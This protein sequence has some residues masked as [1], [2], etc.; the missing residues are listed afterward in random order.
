MGRRDGSSQHCWSA[1]CW[2][3]R[4]LVPRCGWS[5]LLNWLRGGCQDCFRT[6]N[7]GLI[8]PRAPTPVFSGLIPNRLVA[9]KQTE[10]IEKYVRLVER[11]CSVTC[12]DCGRLGKANDSGWIRTQSDACPENWSASNAIATE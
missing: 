7:A 5:F 10:A 1:G 2:L 3:R 12:E 6:S 4:A 11:L 9:H 8:L